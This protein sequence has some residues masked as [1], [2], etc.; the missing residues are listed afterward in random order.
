MSLF[1][2][3]TRTLGRHRKPN[4]VV[5]QHRKRATILWMG[6][7]LSI[8]GCEKRKKCMG[9]VQQNIC[10]RRQR[11]RVRG[12]RTANIGCLRK[13]KKGSLLFWP[14]VVIRNSIRS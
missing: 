8:V 13:I 10:I 5:T 7:L 3:H 2:P 4:D 12:R 11:M 1:R 6:L 14:F 9:V